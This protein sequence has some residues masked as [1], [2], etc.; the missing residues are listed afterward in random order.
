MP[1]LMDKAARYL[2][3]SGPLQ[4]LRNRSRFRGLNIDDD[5]SLDV[6]GDLQYGAGCSIGTGA[7]ISVPRGATLELGDG[8]YVGRHVE[9]GPSGK[10]RIGADTSIQDRCILLGE[11]SIGRYCRFAPNIFASSGRHYFD[12]QPTWLIQ[13]QDRLAQRDPALAAQHNRPIVVEDDCWLGINCVLLP[14]I[15]VGKGAVIGAGSVVSRDVDPYTVVAGSPAKPIR[16]RLE[17]SPPRRVDFANSADWPYFYAGFEISQAAMG[18]NAAHGGFVA[19]GE[20]TL[21]LD[22]REAA[23]LHLV[24]KSATA[25][26]SLVSVHGQQRAATDRFEDLVF[27]LPGGAAPVRGSCATAVAVREAWVE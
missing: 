12:L 19:R 16:K 22:T 25:A 1:S 17:F 18:A 14:G 13:D 7:N 2:G 6:S 21:S 27:E 9:L 11:I 24:A 3:R 10:L 26:Q 8:C 20:F 15:T 23:S 5:V 4:R